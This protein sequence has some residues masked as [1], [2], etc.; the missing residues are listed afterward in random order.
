[1]NKKWL[2]GAAV[3]AV[4]SV[5]A[6]P[7]MLVTAMITVVSGAQQQVSS[8]NSSLCSASWQGE[9]VTESDLTPAQL[10]AA[11]TIYAAAN[12]AGVGPEGAIVGIATA[13]QESNLG[14][15]PRILLPN[16]DGDV[17]LFQQR[18]LVGW[19]A[20]GA[21]QQENIDTLND[22]AYA[23]RV[24]FLGNDTTTGYHIPGLV[25]IDDWRTMSVTEAAQAVQR[26]AFPDAYAKHEALSRALVQRLSDG[27]AGQILCA[28][29]IGGSLDCSPSGLS[30]EVGLNADALRGLRCIKQYWP[31]IEVIG[32]TRNDPD[33]DH[34]V[35]NAVDPMIPNYLTDQGIATGTEI[36]EWAKA[37]AQG[38]GVKYVIWRR[39]LWSTERAD[40]G[41]RTCGVTASCYSGTDHS[42]AHLDHVHISFYGEM[43]TGIPALTTMGTSV[44]G[45]VSLP[46]D[47]GKYRLTARYNQKGKAWSSGFHTGLDFAAPEGTTLRSITNG[48]V[49][50]AQWHSAYG[51]LTKITADDG[52]VFFYAH[53]ASRYVSVGTRVQAGQ[54]IGTV[55]NTGNS[56]GA[57]LHLEVRINGR[58]TDPEAWLIARGI[59]P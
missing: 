47:R 48:T 15:D 45:D 57:H 42:A 1:M 11:A 49:T 56:Y 30:T 18:S 26:S 2:I 20:N 8:V 34:H 33:S 13:L 7:F 32:G 44:S 24:F 12:D 31:Q 59:N 17:G 41:W 58:H 21:T 38:L 27:A 39:Q 16:A 29:A 25:D 55:G 51:N 23:A 28:G 6:V 36:A 19:Y 50:T 40:E 4:L 10:N 35:G 5:V 54:P 43:G 22:H 37:N 46:I 9:G 53:Q 52:T 14:A 3:V